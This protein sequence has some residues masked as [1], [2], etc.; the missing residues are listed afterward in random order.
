M[1]LL[2]TLV[3]TI[4]IIIGGLIGCL[5]TKNIKERFSTLIMSALG[6]VSMIIGITFSIKSS[7]ILI[8]ILSLVIG[9]VIGEWI[10]FDKHLNNLGTLAE[11][12]ISGTKNSSFSE[13]FVT[14]SLLFCVGSMAIMGA[15]ES[16]LSN[17]HTILYT[18]SIMDG[19][20]ALIFSTT[21]GIGVV[22]SSVSVF[23]YQGAITLIASFI[24]PYVS[25]AVIVE[26]NAVGGIL[27]MGIG[28]SLL[29]IKTIKVAN[30]LPALLLPGIIMLFI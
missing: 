1:I 24:E 25:Q 10:D 8:V 19:I 30:L 2:G 4:A 6:L 20:S 12:K 17:N 9:G 3:N 26:M 7:N 28:F 22:L 21:L 15:L 16:G 23:L 11:K 13:G 29:N 27:L 18:K 5:T 14:S